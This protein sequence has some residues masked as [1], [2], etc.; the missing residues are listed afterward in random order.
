MSVEGIN[1]GMCFTGA[2]LLDMTDINILQPI[3]TPTSSELQT[4]YLSPDSNFS[5]SNVALK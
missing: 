5:Y 2:E 1:V 3:C 4:K